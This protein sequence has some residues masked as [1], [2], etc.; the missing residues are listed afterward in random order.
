MP[1]ADEAGGD[2]RRDDAGERGAEDGA[3]EVEAAD[4]DRGRRGGGGAGDELREAEVEEGLAVGV[5]G[6]VSHLAGGVGDR[7]SPVRRPGGRDGF[8][9]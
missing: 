7:A 1:A 8:P 6:G 3:E 9:T 2:D 4:Q 5:A